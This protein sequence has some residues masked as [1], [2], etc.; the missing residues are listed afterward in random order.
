MPYYI[1]LHDSIK[2]LILFSFINKE[3]EVQAW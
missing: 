3:N 1:N 2:E